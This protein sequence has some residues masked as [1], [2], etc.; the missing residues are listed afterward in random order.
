MK[1]MKFLK[2]ILVVFILGLLW[3]LPIHS[4][5]QVNL[6]KNPSF[7]D[8]VY[9]PFG[10]IQV[11]ACV[12][13]MN[14]GMSPDYFHACATNGMNVPNSGF[15]YQYAH[16]GPGMC[17]LITYIDPNF[18]SNYRETIGSSL[19][20]QTQVGVKYYLSFHVNFSN[21]HPLN[22]IASNN[23]GIK[24]ST[25][26][27]D[28]ASP[29]PLTNYSHLRLSSIM[30]DSANWLKVSGSLIADSNYQYIMIGN[31]YEDEFTDTINLANFTQQAYYY[32]DDV[33]VS[34]DSNYNDT[35]TVSIR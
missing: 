29:P 30:T 11:D 7:D 16:S 17:G 31:F 4:Q 33:C 10:V 3:V 2:R 13:W 14:F 27:F 19:I 9:C 6:V 15:G 24:L 21:F 25:V 32:I 26:P 23:I 1:K 28:S 5:A 12:D 20:S 18:S 22:A 34:V 8:Y 35:W